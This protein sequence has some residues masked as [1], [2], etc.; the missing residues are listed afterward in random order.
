M[1]DTDER[2]RIIHEEL[3]TY[4]HA[5]PVAWL[6]AALRQ[7]EREIT[8]GQMSDYHKGFYEGIEATKQTQPL[9]MTASVPETEE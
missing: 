1:I 7:F 9:A 5:D 6:A 3:T 8:V 2:A 4:K